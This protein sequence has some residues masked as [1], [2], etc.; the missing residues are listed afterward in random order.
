M[1]VVT[2]DT[3]PLA[4]A[5]AWIAEVDGR[6]SP[7]AEIDGQICHIETKESLLKAGI[8]SCIPVGDG[9]DWPHAVQILEDGSEDVRTLWNT[10]TDPRVVAAAARWLELADQD[11]LKIGTSLL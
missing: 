9:N 11:D 1:K 8:A 10:T 4:L 6:P 3:E 5:R 2:P 7:M